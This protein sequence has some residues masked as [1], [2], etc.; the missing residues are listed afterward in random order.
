[1][2]ASEDV[3][4]GLTDEDFSVCCKDC[5]TDLFNIACKNWKIADFRFVLEKVGPQIFSEFVKKI[6]RGAKEKEN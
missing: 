1:M 5:Y 4:K 2:E 6:P 3:L